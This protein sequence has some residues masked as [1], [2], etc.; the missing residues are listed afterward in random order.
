MM[1]TQNVLK[2]S[3]NSIGGQ[4]EVKCRN[5]IEAI[6]MKQVTKISV[7]ELKDMAKRMYAPIVKAVV[8][9]NNGCVVI[10]AEMHVD[11]E[12]YQLEQGSQ[13]VDLWG[14]NLHPHEYGTDNFI[15]YDS[16]INIRP[17]QNNPSRSVHDEK[18]R[19]RVDEII[20]GVVY[21]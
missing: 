10:D 17:S 1:A 20:A 15:E 21:E 7:D 3:K 18:I 5:Y 19:Q 2:C 8:D 9:V 11:E 12:Q 4:N 16:M 6:H 13:Q 14:I